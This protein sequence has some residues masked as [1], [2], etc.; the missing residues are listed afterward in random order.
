MRYDL[1]VVGGGVAGS[2]LAKVMAESGAS[3]LVLERER[4]FRDRV[5]GEGMHPWGVAE[6]RALALY[7]ELIDGGGA[8][9]VQW[10]AS[11]RGAQ[12]IRRR[13]LIATTRQRCGGLNFYHPRMQQ[14]LLNSAAAAGAEIRRGIAVAGLMSGELPAVLLQAGSEREAV[15]A[16]LVV[17]A[18]GRQSMTRQWAGF[19]ISRDPEW[20]RIT[21]VLLSG[22]KVP[23]DAVHV[24]RHP[25]FGQSV[26]LFPLGNERCRAYFTT[27]RRMEDDVLTGTT[28]FPAFVA[29][30]VETGVPS[31]WFAGADVS[32]PLATFEGADAWVET[33][34]KDGVVLV[35]DAAAASDPCFGCG[36]SLTL[37]DIRVLRDRLLAMDDWQVAA[38]QYAAE[39]DRYYSAL[40][41]ITSWL[42]VV[43]YGLGPEVDR[44]REHALPR[45]SD[46]SGPDLVGLGP[47]CPADERARI[48]FL[49]A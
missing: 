15:A 35:G 49:G 23:D 31:E 40:H 28:H 41:T 10:W 22:M 5:R 19:T 4:Q 12:L 33:P 21:G 2:A 17:A 45:L 3:V 47:D 27:G 44:I 9:S 26:L 30:C 38:R 29:R 1:I 14:A 36:L 48:H 7:D 25:A 34:Y 16:R 20:L 43:L 8:H 42:R 37:R 13:D 39:H 6:T 11:Y 18:D 32:G 24:F 46:G